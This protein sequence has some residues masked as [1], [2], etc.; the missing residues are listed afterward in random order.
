[1]ALFVRALLLGLASW[2]VPFAF[3]FA[4]FPLRKANA[5]LFGS[6]M[7][8]VVLVTAGSLLSFY[9]LH[10]AVSARESA[11][12]GLLWLAMNLLIDY[13]LFA[14]GPMKMTPLAYYS[15][16]GLVYLTFPLFAV[17]AA[18]LARH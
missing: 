11:L 10:R 9:F 16:I 8:L 4:L 17:L 18:P 13:P 15:E 3:S 6:L 5:P 14:Y 12:V 1:M 2:L 7:E